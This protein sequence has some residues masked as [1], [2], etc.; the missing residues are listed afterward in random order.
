M[1]DGEKM[2]KSK[3]NFYRISD[4]EEK[5]FDPLALR[6]FYMTAHYRAFLNFTW[7]ALE[8]A[9]AALKELRSQLSALRLQLSDRTTLSQEKLEKIDAY[10][11]QFDA[12][13]ANELNM[14]QA[15]AVVWEVVKSNIP[16]QDKYDLLMDFDEVLG[17]Q[18]SAVSYQSSVIPREIEELVQKREELRKQQKF[19]EADEARKQIEEKGYTVEDTSSGPQIK[20]L[21]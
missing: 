6:Y 5:S 9:H 15:L 4:I 12:A 2:S 20:Q 19:A 16:S 1:V 21:R 11:K 10:R 13:L 7:P 14:P 3:E 18:L 8:A 17:L